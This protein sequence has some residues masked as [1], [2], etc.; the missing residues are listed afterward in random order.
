MKM[1]KQR[2]PKC[3]KK[4][5]KAYDFCPYCGR[6]LKSKNDDEDYGFIGKNDFLNKD[7]NSMMSIG[8]G[9]ILDKMIKKAMQELPALM[10][11]ME[12]QQNSNFQNNKKGQQMPNNMKIRFMVNGKEIPVR[13]LG[14]NQMPRQQKQEPQKPVAPQLSSEQSKQLAKLPRKEPKTKLKRFS[15]KLIYELEVPGV[16]NIQDI[17][18]N[19]LENSIEIKAISS[20]TVYSK[21]ININLPILRYSLNDGSLILELQAK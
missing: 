8:G 2:C 14:G 3:E 21:T 12:E 1:F 5:D 7:Q 17:I 18:I 15:S 19:K 9:S 4:I 10:K 16:E 11:S 13:Q 6:N 20:K